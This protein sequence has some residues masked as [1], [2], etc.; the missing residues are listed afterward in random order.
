MYYVA[1]VD[2]RGATRKVYEFPTRDEAVA[3]IA[4]LP[5]EYYMVVLRNDEFS[6]ANSP[7][8]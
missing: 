6:Y 3:F 2:V 5:D 1:I 8:E 7:K 4:S